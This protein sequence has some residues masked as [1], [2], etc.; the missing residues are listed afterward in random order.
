MP[1]QLRG[2]VAI[3][4][5]LA[6][7]SAQDASDSDPANDPFALWPTVDPTSLA[8]ALNISMNCLDAMYVDLSSE[9]LARYT[10]PA[11]ELIFAM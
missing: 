2:L 6:V 4:G 1:S 7:A 3:F 8:T 10:D 11:Q 5:L 9:Q